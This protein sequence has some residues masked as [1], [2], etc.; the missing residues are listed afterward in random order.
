MLTAKIRDKFKWT[1]TSLW[2]LLAGFAALG[3][4]SAAQAD[5]FEDFDLGFAQSWTFAA[6]DDVGD[7]PLTGVSAFQIIEAGANDYL[8]ISHTTTG[9]ADGGGGATD[10]FGYVSEIFT[11]VAVSA[12]INTAPLDGHQSLLGVIA[13]GDPVFGTAYAAGVG[14]T[15][16]FFAIGRTDNFED[17]FVPLAVD[18]SVSIDPNATHVVQLWVLGSTLTARLLDA[19]TREILSTLFTTDAS[20]TSGVSGILVETNY[21]FADSPI[22]PIVGTFD[23]VE[24]LPEP[25]FAVLL[26][27]G[28][29]FLLSVSARSVRVDARNRR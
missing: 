3:M 15:D 28:F 27:A 11:D 25:G 29:C 12:E 6:I 9:I 21:D 5:W 1:T 26:S 23:E 13:R 20:Y 18:S 2:R 16:S 10:G 22:G 17:F 8:R 4:A 7:P 19:S 24:A 14:Y